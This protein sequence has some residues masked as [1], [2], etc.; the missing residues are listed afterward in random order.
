MLCFIFSIRRSL[1]FRAGF[2]R[3]S[4]TIVSSNAGMASAIRVSMIDRVFIC[5]VWRRM[6][7]GRRQK[8]IELNH[9]NQLTP[10][11]LSYNFIVLLRIVVFRF[12]LCTM[13]KMRH[14]GGTFSP[15]MVEVFA[16]VLL[17]FNW[18]PN[19]LSF[20]PNYFEAKENFRSRIFISGEA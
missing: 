20:Y 13:S 5:L 15:S 4:A 14:K 8:V 12:P 17:N 11:W 9:W 16:L 2:I 18:T 10:S 1:N 3:D 6:V 7:I 19:F